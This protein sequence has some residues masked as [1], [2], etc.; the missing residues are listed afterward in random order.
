MKKNVF[1]A[2]AVTLGTVLMATPVLPATTAGIGTAAVGG[3]SS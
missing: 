3:I 1:L 2:A